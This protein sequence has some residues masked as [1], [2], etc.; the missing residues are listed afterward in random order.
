MIELKVPRDAVRVVEILRGRIKQK[1]RAADRRDAVSGGGCDEKTLILLERADVQWDLVVK[2]SDAASYD[3][4]IRISRRDD[5]A[6]TR[7][8][9]VV[10]PDTVSIVAKSEI[11]HETRVHDPLVLHKC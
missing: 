6:E 10:P 9:V 2:K 5:K 11:E 1:T 3:S 7:R 4:S 8:E